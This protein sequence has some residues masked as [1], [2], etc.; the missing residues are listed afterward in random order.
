[1]RILF[2]EDD[3]ITIHATKEHLELLGHI[4][5]IVS[6]TNEAIDRIESEEYDVILIDIM[7]PTGKYFTL[8]D[9]YEGRYT[10]LKIIEHIKTNERALLNRDKKIFLI[11][12]WRDNP[13][14]EKRS[15]QFN[16]PIINKPLIISELE[17]VL[18]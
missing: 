11:T 10:G 5:E 18:K 6:D 13:L 16:I 3:Y 17:K 4:V 9:T 15:E 12:N 2:I 14:V 1:M 7:L 8:E